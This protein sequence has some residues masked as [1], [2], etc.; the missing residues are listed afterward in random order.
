MR[1]TSALINNNNN[2]NNN[3]NNNNNNN[4]NAIAIA[5]ANNTP[6]SSLHASF[7]ARLSSPHIHTNT[8]AS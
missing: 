1:T 7:P 4:I 2:I 6:L 5:T 8:A 3:I